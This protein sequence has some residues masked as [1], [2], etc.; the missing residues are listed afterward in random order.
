M[1]EK[2]NKKT[3]NQE[4]LPVLEPSKEVE[5][6]VSK[7]EKTVTVE[8]DHIENEPK[9]KTVT[10]EKKESMEVEEKRREEE[11]KLKESSPKLILILVALFLIVASFAGYYVFSSNP[12]RILISSITAFNKKITKLSTD[13]QKSQIDLG[14]D[15]ETKGTVRVKLTSD[16][17][18][19]YAS[20]GMYPEMNRV[21]ENIGNTDFEYTY[22]QNLT[23]KQLYFDV[24]PKLN[25][26]EV[27][28]IR[29]Y[30]N[31][32]SQ[33]LFIKEIAKNYLQ[34]DKLDIFEE[35]ANENKLD[36]YNYVMDIVKESL[37]QNVKKD[38]FNVKNVKIKV[39]GK[40][41]EVKK[42][43]LSLT[44]KTANE[45]FNAIIKDLKKDK[46]ANKIMNQVSKG[47]KSYNE[48]D[49]TNNMDES[50]LNITAYVTKFAHEPLKYAITTTDSYTKKESGIAYTDGET[51]EIEII[52][53]EKVTGTV[54]ITGNWES[55]EMTFKDSKGTSIGKLNGENKKSSSKGSISFNL[56][57]ENILACNYKTTK[58]E[59]SEKFNTTGDMECKLLGSNNA[60]YLT[61]SIVTQEE[62]KK[63]S[64]I[65]EDVTNSQKIE[66]V[67]EESF[68]NWLQN[69]IVTYMK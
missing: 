37:Y 14:N 62:S 21:I 54:E 57:K 56:D 51:N 28:N 16:I 17:L 64:N 30:N 61:L 11:K 1:A 55:F 63:G 7:E 44:P 9:E 40:E 18:K 69:I 10:E 68:S 46:K 3:E 41:K 66:T 36:D 20:L 31:N 23:K 35:L 38:Y 33:Y 2:E 48:K 24:T 60:N 22:Q 58:K 45:V 52:D 50:K 15:F 67:S 42:V 26:Q 12:K 6:E 59:A 13:M 29:Y 39:D 19:S 27:T 25:G 47:F 4:E 49:L 34:L 53:N 8:N 5:M 65:K 32:S 43:T